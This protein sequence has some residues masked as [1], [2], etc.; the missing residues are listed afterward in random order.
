V[1]EG[2]GGLGWGWVRSNK[3][4][5]TKRMVTKKIYLALAFSLA[6]LTYGAW[7][8]SPT[9]A[10]SADGIK[11]EAVEGKSNATVRVR[12]QLLGRAAPN[13]AVLT[14]S[15]VTGKFTLRPDGTFTSDSRLTVDLSTLSSDD[16]RRDNFIKQNTLETRRFPVAEF[17]PIKVSEELPLP[18]PASGEW[19]FKV[20]GNLTIRGVEKEVTWDIQ[21]RRSEGDLTSIATTKFKFGDFGME[22]PRVFLVLSI[23]DEIRLEVELQ[24]VEKVEKI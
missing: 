3:K 8:A 17:V 10:A 1:G 2:R 15:V 9:R 18:L 14:T 11:F 20:T 7:E 19:A 24:S 21:A 13:D 4:G 16:G 12:E 23:V 5:K 6:I 22:R